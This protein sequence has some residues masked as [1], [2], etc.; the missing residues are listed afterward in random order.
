M[1]AVTTGPAA[2][3]PSTPTTLTGHFTDCSG[4]A[5]TP[6]AFDAVKQPSGAASAHLVDGSGIFIVIAA[7]DVESGRTLFATPG[8]EH[9]NLPTITCRLIHPVTQRLL[10]VAGFIAPIH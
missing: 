10:S 9:N 8:F 1:L 7:I 5:G 2:A 6:A 3:H 4:P